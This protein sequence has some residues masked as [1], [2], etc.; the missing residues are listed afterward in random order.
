MDISRI[1]ILVVDDKSSMREAMAS[2]LSTLGLTDITEAE[3]GQAAWTCIKDAAAGQGAKKRFDL[4]I[5]DMEMPKMTGLELLRT[6]R[7]EDR[8]R[9]TRFIM[10]TTVTSRQVILE[11]MRLGINAYLLKPFDH[12]SVTC[13]LKQAGVL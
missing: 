9:H 2:I 1:K 8:T 12:Q 5:S 3:D 6:V 13:K 7:K 4:I 11:T 10:A